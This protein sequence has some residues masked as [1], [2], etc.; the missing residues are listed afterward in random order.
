[1]AATSTFKQVSILCIIIACGIA[2][3]LA[4]LF[5]NYK[6]HSG[7]KQFAKFYSAK[8]NLES[9]SPNFLSVKVSLYTVVSNTDMAWN[10]FTVLCIPYS[11]L[12]FVAN[13]LQ[14]PNLV[15][16]EKASDMWLCDTQ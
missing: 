5:V 10:E 4:L 14:L 15:S 3:L 16:V 13:S 12:Y 1:M 9:N 7:S 11:A 2:L 6:G 8:N